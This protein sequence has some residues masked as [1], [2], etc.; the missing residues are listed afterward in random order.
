MAKGFKHGSGGSSA[1]AALNFKIL[2]GT[3]QPSGASENT[4]W[5][6]TSEDISSWVLSPVEPEGAEGLVWILTG[7]VSEVA[8]NALKKNGIMVYPL[9]VKQYV[10]G[11]WVTR[12]AKSYIGGAWVDWWIPGTLLANGTDGTDITGGWKSSAY[13]AGSG[14]E[15]V[16]ASFS[17]GADGLS[18]ALND[19]SYEYRST[20]VGTKNKVD[21]SG[22]TTLEV[23]C[24]EAKATVGRTGAV[25][26]SLYSDEG[27]STAKTATILSTENVFTGKVNLDVS[28]LT[29]KYYI[30]LFL[31]KW[32]A[33]CVVS[34]K[35]PLMRLS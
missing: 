27:Y 13:S 17:I 5:I 10:S 25:I 32:D 31:W 14:Y 4:I 6:N 34:V 7:S 22:Y 28:G 15:A 16:V 20:F 18:V 12:T 8:F 19:Q 35:M 21:L 30:G 23:E 29:G 26:V 9:E 1:S 33:S 3:E 11:A 2:G 24:S